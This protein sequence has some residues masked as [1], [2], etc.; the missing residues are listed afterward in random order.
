MY[1]LKD[2]R[3]A[4]KLAFCLCSTMVYKPPLLPG[5]CR[6]CGTDSI[7]ASTLTSLDLPRFVVDESAARPIE[8]VTVGRC[9]WR[10]TLQSGEDCIRGVNVTAMLESVL[11]TVK[12]SRRFSPSVTAPF[13]ACLLFSDSSQE[14]VE[15]LYIAQCTCSVGTV[16]A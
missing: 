13:R 7:S 6:S 16:K 10:Q 4:V 3:P 11:Q 8:P 15:P 14:Q 12:L 2:K 5:L 1:S 9:S